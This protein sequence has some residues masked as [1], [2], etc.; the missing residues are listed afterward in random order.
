MV[1]AELLKLAERFHGHIC[2]FLVLGLRAS[3]IAFE[4][5]V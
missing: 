5:L 4:N 3:E 1:N 2:P